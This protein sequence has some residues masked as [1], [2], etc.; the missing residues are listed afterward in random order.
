MNI[1]EAPP[2]RGRGRLIAALVLLGWI[3]VV[4]V[5]ASFA[6][7]LSG[8]QSNDQ[9]NYLPASAQA[10]RVAQLQAALP[11]G[12]TTDVIVAYHRDGAL[13]L[14]DRTAINNQIA[15]LT[16][17]YGI[18]TKSVRLTTASN[19]TM[20]PL[21][22]GVDYGADTLVV[23]DIRT[24]I[25]TGLPAGLTVQVTGPG[26]L[27]AD[28]SKVFK[29]IDKT[30]LIVTVLVVAVLLIG[31]YRSPLLWAIPLVTVATGAVTAMAV[32]YGLV[33]AFDLVV[34]TQSS[35]IMTVLIF[36]AGTD[37]ALL[38]VSRYR[39]E[40]R[41]HELQY[42]AVK[43]AL[44][45]SGPAV[46]A[47][48]ATVIAAL[49]CLLAADNNSSKGLG[50]V[51]AVG[52]LA[53][54]IAMLTMLPALLLLTG[55]RVFWPFIPRVDTESVVRR[56]VF[57]RVGSFVGRRPWAVLTVSVLVLGGLTVGALLLPGDLRQADAFT[58]TPESVAGFTTITRD[59]PDSG[60]EPITVMVRSGH[61]TE[62]LNAVR[63]TEG[64]TA[65]RAG[66]TGTDW[67]EITAFPK[68]PPESAGETAT[69]LRL[70]ADLAGIPGAEALV[71]GIGAQQID[72]Q[73]TSSR[74][75]RLVIPLV[76]VV[77]LL[78]LAVLLRS[79]V[80]PI[81]LIAAVIGSWAAAL[82]LSGL[83]FKPILGFAGTD[84]SFLLLSFVFLVALG[85]DYGIFLTHRIREEAARTD[86]R[87]A[88]GIGLANTGTVLASAGVV[89]AATFTVLTVL[90]LVMMVELGFAVA[91]GVL[92]ATL[93]VQPFLVTSA[94]TL[95]G[96][97]TWW[98]GR[99]HKL[100]HLSEESEPNMFT[101]TTLE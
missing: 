69:I 91:A 97:R 47:S 37:Y 1:T 7:K 64:V 31:T 44:R 87:E 76:L 46:L 92:L 56:G 85:V 6:G 13:T 66:R 29:G 89:L 25:A 59:F 19:A 63:A 80:A 16:G 99:V 101:A 45:G 42:D 96:A 84:P 53:T 94:T 35:S 100:A 8:V 11:G 50:P 3:A 18:A 4:T 5:S 62:V 74:D 90:P 41:R 93:V 73:A 81:L 83:V 48:A 33:R 77:V 40:L 23:P 67:S 88:P 43:A 17:K 54:L 51:G 22:I 65:A 12:Q 15:T 57:A 95:L 26:A 86:A 32:V 52:I 9:V 72:D 70:R 79:L 82:G 68:D 39:E 24:A 10:T 61:E 27:K 71:G 30:L 60:G 14:D 20:Y 2:R 55:R 36:G 78:I 98:P 75:S 34:S 21:S 58:K 28:L 49:L 38:L